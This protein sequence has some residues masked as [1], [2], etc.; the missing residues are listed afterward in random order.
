MAARRAI[1]ERLRRVRAR[2]AAGTVDDGL[3]A[4]IARGRA[5]RDLDER[6]AEEILGYDDSGLPR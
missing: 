5:R 4:I 3:D 2:A 1:E 6:T